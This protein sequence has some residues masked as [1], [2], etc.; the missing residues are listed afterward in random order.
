MRT[1]LKYEILEPSKSILRILSEA[2]ES[3]LGVDIQIK[4]IW[5]LSRDDTTARDLF[6]D[7]IDIA[8]KESGIEDYDD[9]YFEAKYT[10]FNQYGFQSIRNICE[11]YFVIRV[12][13]ISH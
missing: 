4:I 6:G 7:A 10:G 9:F 13:G 8:E 12:T 11:Y 5:D 1:N 2:N 3:A